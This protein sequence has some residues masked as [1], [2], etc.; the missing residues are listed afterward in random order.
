MNF[1]KDKETF[2]SSWDLPFV[3]FFAI[4]A[5]L[6]WR[7]TAPLIIALL[8][9]AL[10]AFLVSPIN[11][12][13]RRAVLF[14]KKEYP[15]VAA[16]LTLLLAA[17]AILIP[18]AAVFFSLSAEIP[19]MINLAARFLE[20]SDL[21]ANAAEYIPERAPVWVV[22]L[23]DF[24]FS[25][26][27]SVR[28]ILHKTAQLAITA[29]TSFSKSIFHGVATFLFEFF[30]SLMAAFFFIRDGEK[31][32]AYTKSITPLHKGEMEMFYSRTK[33][34]LNSVILGIVLTV[35]IQ[36]V[37]GAAGWWMVGL[38]NPVFFG[39]LMFCFG[40]FPMGTAAVWLPGSIYLLASG[41]V[42]GG[43]ILLAWGSIIVSTIDNLLRPFIISS[44]GEQIS[45]LLVILGLCGGVIAWGFIGV[46]L[47]PVLIV[48]FISVL[49][50]YRSRR[51]KNESS[52]S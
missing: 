9:G 33:N 12:R 39:L 23:A 5:L 37:L 7:L 10:L 21:T 50:I 11:T 28:D 24:F 38:S 17:L 22:S 47:G 32:I 8:W 45:T 36:A 40:M 19:A 18:L 46:F 25:N 6:A 44:G 3:C 48:L 26:P 20:K 13:L 27:D 4:F 51:L 29:L 41:D 49:D 31:I 14:R 30:V 52:L 16:A 2:C 35:A 42:K 1:I 15:S 34:L 43:L